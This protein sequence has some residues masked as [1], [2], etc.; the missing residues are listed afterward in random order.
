MNNSNLVFS[1][2]VSLSQRLHELEDE[3]RE[4]TE[5]EEELWIEITALI[6][7]YSGR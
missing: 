4:Y 3:G 7:Q 6:E 2:L 5:A 1:M